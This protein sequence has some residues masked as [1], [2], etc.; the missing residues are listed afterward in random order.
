MSV[1]IRKPNLV[2]FAMRDDFEFIAIDRAS[3][4][5]ERIASR[6]HPPISLAFNAQPSEEV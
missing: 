3:A 5:L 4:W 1:N 6:A 2:F